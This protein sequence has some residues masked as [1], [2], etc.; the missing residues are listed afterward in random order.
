LENKWKERVHDFGWL[1]EKFWPLPTVETKMRGE[2]YVWPENW[3]EYYEGKC[4]A[5]GA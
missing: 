1:V 4:T 3:K 5:A 2:K